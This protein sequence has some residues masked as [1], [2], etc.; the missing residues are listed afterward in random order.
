VKSF[1]KSGKPFDKVLKILSN[2]SNKDRLSKSLKFFEK[3]SV[4]DS[5]LD[6]T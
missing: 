2:F 1:A 5:K 3:L 4:D 6:V